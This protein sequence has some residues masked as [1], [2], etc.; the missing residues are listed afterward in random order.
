MEEFIRYLQF[1]W[2]A[3]LISAIMSLGFAIQH[4]HWIVHVG[5]HRLRP[6]VFVGLLGILLF[7]LF[8]ILPSAKV[9][10]TG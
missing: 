6:A 7:I 1:S 8:L 2:W 9:G 3:I 10:I 4:W 5:R